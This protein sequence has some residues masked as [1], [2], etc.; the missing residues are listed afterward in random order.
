MLC[1][2]QA[3]GRYEVVDNFVIDEWLD[4]KIMVG[5]SSS[6]FLS[7]PN[8]SFRNIIQYDGLPFML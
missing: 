7:Y 2:W 6:N 3:D 4:E 8:G 5:H 1:C